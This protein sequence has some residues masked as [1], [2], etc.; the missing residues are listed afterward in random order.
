[1]GMNSRGPFSGIPVFLTAA[2]ISS[3]AMVVFRLIRSSFGGDAGMLA[4]CGAVFLLGIAAASIRGGSKSGGNRL[5]VWS[6]PVYGF[7]LPLVFGLGSGWGAFAVALAALFLAGLIAAR[8]SPLANDGPC[9]H[10]ASMSFGVPAG[11]VLALY[12]LPG[13]G[14]TPVLLG[15]FIFLVLGSP[16]AGFLRPTGTDPIESGGDGPGGSTTPILLFLMGSAA[17]LWWFGSTRLLDLLCGETMRVMMIAVSVAFGA[18]GIGAFLGRHLLPGRQFV[19]PFAAVLAAVAA[20]ITIA[21][22]GSLP[23]FMVDSIGGNGHQFEKVMLAKWNMAALLLV[24]AMLMIGVALSRLLPRGVEGNGSARGRA[25]LALGLLF[26]LVAAPAQVGTIGIGGALLAAVLFLLLAALLHLVTGRAWGKGVRIAVSLAILA[27]MLTFGLKMP[28]W[29]GAALST[30]P[31]KY[32]SVYRLLDEPDFKSRYARAPT[33]YNEG[34]NGTVYT[35]DVPEN[36]DQRINGSGEIGDGKHQVLGLLL[37]RIPLL[38]RKDAGELLLL[39]A[40]R[41]ITAGALLRPATVR[42]SVVEPLE[43]RAEATRRSGSA[44][45][46]Y[47]MDD[48]VVFHIGDPRRFLSNDDG[49]YDLIVVSPHEVAGLRGAPLSTLSFFREAEGRL[50]ETGILAFWVPLVGMAESHIQSI[51]GTARQVFPHLVGFHASRHQGLVV[52]AGRQPLRI[53]AAAALESWE[54]PGFSGDF[55]EAGVSSLAHLISFARFDEDAIDLWVPEVVPNDDRRSFV[56]F[57]AEEL[58]TDLSSRRHFFLLKSLPFDSRRI[59]DFTGTGDADRADFDFQT[60]RAFR[61]ARNARQGYAFAEEAYRLNPTTAS[62][63]M[64]AHFVKTRD[65]DL[66]RVVEILG[67]AWEKD[68]EDALLIRG[69][70]DDLYLSGHFRECADLMTEIID[71]RDLGQSW[72]YLIRGKARLALDE[73]DEAL[74]D[75]LEAK[76]LNRL[77]D[78]SG[79]YNYFLGLAYK[80]REMYEESNYYLSRALGANNRHLNAL[81]AYG[82]NRMLLGEIDR[83]QFDERFY[84]PFNRGRADSLYNRS[85]DHFYESEYAGEVERDLILVI[86]STPNHVG[87]YILLAEFYLRGGNEGKEGEVI[88]RMVA[89]FNASE[90]CLDKLDRYVRNVGGNRGRYDRIVREVTR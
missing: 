59:V 44:D 80:K 58:M 36:S 86:N 12:L 17:G 28:A 72:C 74:A 55:D 6:T 75:L 48:R 76:E 15:A 11:A 62:A 29:Q 5:L 43:A 34:K 56:E 84:L 68:P 67:D 14:N 25:P 49:V 85:I 4:L 47:W 13:G 71:V 82:E 81:Y 10:F 23:W 3:Y 89:H 8:F 26:A 39:G 32:V 57:G 63:I 50:G 24:P 54:D 73:D 22:H 77:Q 45:Q 53:S 78:A 64:Y 79:K 87:S 61:I 51:L 30:A 41:G 83:P 65:H 21:N 66:E 33:F 90:G 70:A 42:L 35:L 18:V 7:L 38:F 20:Y 69:Y 60:A 2:G 27:C 19:F 16:A 31:Y 9:D 1:M 52:V 40:G 88:A 37:G 46:E